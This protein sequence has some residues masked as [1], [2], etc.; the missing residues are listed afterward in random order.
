[1]VPQLA[2]LNSTLTAANTR[3]IEVQ[4]LHRELKRIAQQPSLIDALPFMANINNELLQNLK[5]EH[6][7]LRYQTAEL[8]ERFG[9]QHPTMLEIKAKIQS[10]KD[11]I[12]SEVSK[13]IRGIETDYKVAD[14]RLQ[15]LQAAFERKK[16]EAQQL[17]TIGIQ[18]GVLQREAESNQRLYDALLNSMKQTSVSAELKRNNIRIVDAAEVPRGAIRPRPVSNLMR[19]ALIALL[20]G[21]GL[22]WLLE[23]SIPP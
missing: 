2:E 22:A 9:P 11:E 1:M 20:L 21:C 8:E 16:E 7:S 5:G 3:F 13:I 6:A 15:A 4:T 19:A 23:S 18:Y 10:L 14:A 17:N 12:R